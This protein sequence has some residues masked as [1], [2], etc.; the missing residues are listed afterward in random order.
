MTCRSHL[1]ILL[2]HYGDG[3]DG[4]K[5][6]SCS[7]QSLWQLDICTE[8]GKSVNWFTFVLTGI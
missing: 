3:T 8:S 2:V 4:K 7:A 5:F 1:I 6:K